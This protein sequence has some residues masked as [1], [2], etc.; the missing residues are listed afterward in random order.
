MRRGRRERETYGDVG[1]VRWG[2]GEETVP[3][4]GGGQKT[5]KSGIRKMHRAG[6][7]WSLKQGTT[8][9]EIRR[10]IDESQSLEKGGQNTNK[11]RKR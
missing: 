11:R 10:G 6:P 1:S 9:E 4:D 2:Y 5:Y 3:G 8:N 7:E